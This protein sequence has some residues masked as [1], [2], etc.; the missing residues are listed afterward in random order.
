MVLVRVCK[1]VP[2]F[3]L[4]FQK[5]QKSYVFCF[6]IHIYI[7]MDVS[8]N[9]GSPQIIEFNKVF[10]DKPSILGYPYFGNTHI[11]L[12]CLCSYGSSNPGADQHLPPKHIPPWKKSQSGLKFDDWEGICN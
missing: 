11:Y 4:E 8:E 6:Y 5:L 2:D 3:H 10:H 7:Y 12:G 1:I 9:S